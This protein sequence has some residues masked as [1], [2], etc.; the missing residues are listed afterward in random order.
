[1]GKDITMEHVIKENRFA[2][3]IYPFVDD[4]AVFSWTV[5][6]D[7]RY[8]ADEGGYGM[9]D[10]NQVTLYALFNKEGRFITLFSDQVPE[11]I[12]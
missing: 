10:D 7:G 11:L 5:Q 8:W 2:S 3:F 1:M 12:K 9:T 6:P 4:R